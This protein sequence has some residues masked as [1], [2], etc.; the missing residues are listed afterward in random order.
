MIYSRVSVFTFKNQYEFDVLF[1]SITLKCPLGVMVC[2]LLVEHLLPIGFRCG[3]HCFAVFSTAFE[4]KRGGST[5]FHFS[6]REKFLGIIFF[7]KVL[8]LKFYGF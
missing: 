3:L 5:I 7:I 8:L 2:R 4:F 1:I 6:C